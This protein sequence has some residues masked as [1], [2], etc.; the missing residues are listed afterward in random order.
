MKNKQDQ[1]TTSEAG[2]FNNGIGIRYYESGKHAGVYLKNVENGVGIKEWPSGAKLYGYFKDGK[3]DS[4]GLF[5]TSN[6]L[7]YYGKIKDF[8]PVDNKHWFDND[9]NPLNFT[10]DESK[11]IFAKDIDA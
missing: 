7:R 11:D 5:I 2:N 4:L 3:I 8:I 6:K 1:H 10:L 9:N